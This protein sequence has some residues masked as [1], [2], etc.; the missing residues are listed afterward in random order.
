M[1]ELL[2]PVDSTAVDAIGYDKN[3][4]EL[5]VLFRGSQKAYTYFD[6]PPEEYEDLK[7]ADSVGNYV[8]LNIKPNY[9]YRPGGPL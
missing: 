6:V 9:D 1:S 5:Y 3:K 8:N 4:H 2:D 7:T